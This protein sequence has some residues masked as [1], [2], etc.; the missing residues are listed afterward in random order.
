MVKEKNKGKHRFILSMLCASAIMFMGGCAMGTE[1]VKQIKETETD[2]ADQMEQ[3]LQDTY[4]NIEYEVEGIVYAGWNQSYDVMNAYLAG[5]DSYADAF[6]VRRKKE[7]GNIRFEDTYKSMLIRDDLEEKIHSMAEPYFKKCVVYADTNNLW[8][9][10]A[11][12]SDITLQ[13]AIDAG[14]N[15]RCN[16]W[17][18]AAPQLQ[19]VEEFRQATESFMEEWRRTGINISFSFFYLKEGVYEQVTRANRFDMNEPE[20]YQEFIT[21][22]MSD[23]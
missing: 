17:L 22:S 9:S 2:I 15:I 21:K 4:R 18:M 23:N 1:D 6:Q 20:Y 10:D 13:A 3:Y 12:G 7:S 11:V 8:L 16:V 5:G 14:E 19:S